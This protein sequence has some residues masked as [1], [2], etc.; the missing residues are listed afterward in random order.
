MEKAYPRT[1]KQMEELRT[2]VRRFWQKEGAEDGCRAVSVANRLGESVFEGACLADIV[3]LERR[4]EIA[5]EEQPVQ[6]KQAKWFRKLLLAC[7]LG[8]EELPEEF[9]VC[10]EAFTTIEQ[11]E[12]WAKTW[13]TSWYAKG[14]GVCGEARVVDSFLHTAYWIYTLDLQGKLHIEGDRAFLS[15]FAHWTLSIQATFQVESVQFLARREANRILDLLAVV[16]RKAQTR[17]SAY[18]SYSMGYQQ[19]YQQDAFELALSFGRWAAEYA[20]GYWVTLAIWL[21]AYL[22]EHERLL[23]RKDAAGLRR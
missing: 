5:L 9:P 10:L 15:D 8:W 21:S 20:P 22:S 4:L 7:F 12:T 6:D 11:L 3:P 2:L 19:D 16:E 14:Y 13:D 1:V 17:L 23:S 18:E